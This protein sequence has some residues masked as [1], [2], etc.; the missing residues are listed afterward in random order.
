M[1]KPFLIIFISIILLCNSSIGQSE[2]DKN[3]PKFQ[4]QPYEERVRAGDYAVFEEMRATN[5]LRELYSLL[6]LAKLSQF[7]E[8]SP[9]VLENAAATIRTM[10]DHASYHGDKIAEVANKRQDYRTIADSFYLLSLVKSPEAIQQLARFLRDP[11]PEP[12]YEPSA[13]ESYT[14]PIRYSAG[15]A[16]VNALGEDS[17]IKPRPFYKPL[18]MQEI[19]VLADWWDSAASL[20]WRQPKAAAVIQEPE[21]VKAPDKVVTAKPK[22]E[23]SPAAPAPPQ[24]GE[25]LLPLL[26]IL[27]G[28]GLVVWIAAQSTRRRG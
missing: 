7:G 1:N 16:I 22:V 3:Y 14:P 2:I 6:K 27:A 21:Q 9:T 10:P 15:V 18:T 19:E 26:L 12:P 20:P 17:P 8:E 4:L 24:E 23:V 5:R 11:S 13:G 28:A 25:W